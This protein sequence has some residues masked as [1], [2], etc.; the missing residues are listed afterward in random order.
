MGNA[1]FQIFASSYMGQPSLGVEKNNPGLF[2]PFRQP[3]VEG[4]SFLG[5]S[6]VNYVLNE[7][8]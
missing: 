8:Q 5:T 3:K 7:P 4:W 2:K 6:A 1:H